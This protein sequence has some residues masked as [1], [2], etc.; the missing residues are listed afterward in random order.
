MDKGDESIFPKKSRLQ[1]LLHFHGMQIFKA[2]FADFFGFFFRRP[3]MR[4]T[5][6]IVFEHKYMYILFRD[7]KT[8][9]RELFFR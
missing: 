4:R 7:K 2:F 6:P 5:T 9:R 8:A 1:I 3:P